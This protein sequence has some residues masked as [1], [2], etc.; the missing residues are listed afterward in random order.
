MGN[1]TVGCSVLPSSLVARGRYLFQRAKQICNK[2]GKNP[3]P[4][5]GST[6]HRPPAVCR[7]VEQRLQ[8]HEET[9]GT[10]VV[11]TPLDL[12]SSQALRDGTEGRRKTA[13]MCSYKLIPL[14][15][16]FRL[17]HC[18]ATHDRPASGESL[19]ARAIPGKTTNHDN[20]C[21]RSFLPHGGSSGFGERFG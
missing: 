8:T 2:G 14:P 5:F 10:R 17:Y 12:S 15:S 9:R 3:S 4:Q 7:Q 18:D 16:Y 20:V 13:M 11:P 21:A 1:Q 19:W 6:I